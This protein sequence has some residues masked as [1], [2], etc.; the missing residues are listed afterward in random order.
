[1]TA[2]D[3]I[4]N[5]LHRDPVSREW[6]PAAR[7]VTDAVGTAAGYGLTRSP[8][9]ISVRTEMRDSIYLFGRWLCYVPRGM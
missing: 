2:K 3:A 8:S 6:D 1:M 5:L 4:K 9:G 7:V